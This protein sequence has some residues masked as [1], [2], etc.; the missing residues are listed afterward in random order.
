M[1]G[2]TDS[3]GHPLLRRVTTARAVLEKALLRGA[4]ALPDG[5]QRRLAGPPVRLDGQE[6]AV[7]TQLALRLQRLARVPGAET[8]PIPEGR[9]AMLHHTRLVAGEQPVGAV[10][11]L[12]AGD[13]PARLYTPAVTG[14]GPL[15]LL[16]FFH[17]GG[18]MY[19]DLD[20]HDAPCRVLAERAGAR[21]L[22]VTY[23]LAPEHPFPAAYDDALAAYAWAVE[24]AESLGC[25]PARLAVGGDSAGGNLAAGV[26]LEAARR[27]WPLAFQLLVYPMTD[28]EHATRSYTMFDEGFYLTRGFM[29]LA[30]DSYNPP[31]QD[32]RDPRLSP[33]H[34]ELPAGLAPAYVATAGFDPLRDEGEAYARRLSE[35]GV[36]VTLQ[37]FPDQIHG[38]LQIVGVGR[39]SR[40]AVDEIA[41]ALRSGLTA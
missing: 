29:Q 25:D 5:V 35:A 3:V 40:A 13:R 8:M 27:G 21:V 39:R 28:A 12:R 9:R 1:R 34:A 18:F 2:V 6:L 17:G 26:A 32:L 22:A 30:E 14:A 41:D 10:R 24:H 23:R 38:F 4:L 7:E 20:S 37:R 31:G 15:P 36:E 11:D 33:Y 19:G 16:V